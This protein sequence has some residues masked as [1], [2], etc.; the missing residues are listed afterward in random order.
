ML[1]KTPFYTISQFDINNIGDVT[2]AAFVFF[3]N[4]NFL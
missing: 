4:Y 3:V 2:N 1:F